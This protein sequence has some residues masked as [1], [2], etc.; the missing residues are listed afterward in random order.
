MKHIGWTIRYE[1]AHV[2]SM[3]RRT[4][5]EVIN[6]YETLTHFKYKED[7]KAGKVKA[8]KVYVEEE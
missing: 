6:Y 3:T 8:V 4:R 1:N 5:E 2:P 7:R